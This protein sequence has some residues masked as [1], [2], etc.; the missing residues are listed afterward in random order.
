MHVIRATKI[1]DHFLKRQL[2]LQEK[3]TTPNIG[4][5]SGQ[6]F[7]I[8]IYIHGFPKIKELISDV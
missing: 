7:N 5:F 1:A 2:V 3:V 6:L 4:W 8:Y